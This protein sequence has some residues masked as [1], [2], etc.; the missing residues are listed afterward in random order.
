MRRRCRSRG[1]GTLRRGAESYPK[2]PI[3]FVADFF[4]ASFFFF[5]SKTQAQ[6][7][8]KKMGPRLP[9]PLCPHK[10]KAE[11]SKPTGE[12][13]N[14]RS[15]FGPFAPPHLPPAWLIT[16]HHMWLWHPNPH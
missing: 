1:G 3:R 2:P 5:A 4:V 10:L 11:Y 16:Q 9:V 13:S 14:P 8:V 6:V 12:L 15:P 7:G